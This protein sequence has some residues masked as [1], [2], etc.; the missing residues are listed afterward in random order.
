M[1]GAGAKN[2]RFTRSSGHGAALSLIVVLIGLPR[3]MPCK[4][5]ALISRATV[6]REMSKPSRCNS[7]QTGLSQIFVVDVLLTTTVEI[8]LPM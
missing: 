4:P 6:Q 1:F 2:C 3:M 8:S 7:R 5:I